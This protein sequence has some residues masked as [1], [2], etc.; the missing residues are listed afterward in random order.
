[1]GGEVEG[2][3]RPNTSLTEGKALEGVCGSPGLGREQR[4]EEP[5]RRLGHHKYTGGNT[6]LLFQAHIQRNTGI[7]L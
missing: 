2:L 3:R 4:T 6:H 5:S 7:Y 1:M